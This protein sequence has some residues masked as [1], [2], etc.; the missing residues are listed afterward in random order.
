MPQAVSGQTPTLNTISKQTSTPQSIIG[1]ISTPQTGT[2]QVRL[3]VIDELDD[4]IGFYNEKLALLRSIKN[5]PGDKYLDNQKC[6]I[7][8]IY[9][10][11]QKS[12]RIDTSNLGGMIQDTLVIQDNNLEGIVYNFTISP[13]R[14]WL[15]YKTVIGDY[16]QAYE[17]SDKQGLRILSTKSG[18]NTKSILLTIN[19][20][21]WPS[22]PI[23]SPD[24]KFLTYTDFDNKG[25]AQIF[26]FD[27]VNHKNIQ[28]TRFG[29]DRRGW[30]ITQIAWSPNASFIAFTSAYADFKDGGY[31][32]SKV[33][34][35]VIDMQQ[36][37]IQSIETNDLDEVNNFWWGA[38]NLL[39]YEGLTNYL[40]KKKVFI[41]DPVNRSKNKIIIPLEMSGG[42]N[43]FPIT[44]DFRS[45]GILGKE[46]DIYNLENGTLD[47]AAPGYFSPPFTIIKKS[48]GEFWSE[49]CEINP[50]NN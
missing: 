16:G 49:N 10:E 11:S 23:W 50:D 39:L 37:G 48:S 38:K 19:D 12:I 41:Y 32:Y 14:N 22:E 8:R 6:Q 7:I 30:L 27:L 35:N 24:N 2:S 28:I 46:L 42:S 5:I 34:I 43:F 33:D 47:K 15:A 18:T 9:Q 21:A 1:Q 13:N 45:F 4:S 29:E 44:S 25:L 36:T 40:S 31:A 20:G 17:Y 3:V 26:N